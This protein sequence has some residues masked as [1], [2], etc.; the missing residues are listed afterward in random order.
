MMEFHVITPRG[1]ELVLQ[2]VDGRPVL[3]PALPPPA[4]APAPAAPAR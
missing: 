1:S 3:P 4:A 2:M